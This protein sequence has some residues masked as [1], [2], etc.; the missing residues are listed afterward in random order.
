MVTISEWVDR[1]ARGARPATPKP[2]IGQRGLFD[3]SK[4]PRDHKGVQTGGRFTRSPHG[5]AASAPT[6]KQHGGHLFEQ[7]TQA[8]KP[9]Q[10]QPSQS[11][12]PVGGRVGEE[13]AV[14]PSLYRDLEIEEYQ[15]GPHTLWRAG[16]LQPVA[17]R[18][19]T[20][21]VSKQL[22]AS[23][24]PK[25]Y[26]R[27]THNRQRLVVACGMGVDSFAMLVAMK[28][29]GIR[30]DAIHW[31]DTGSER[32]HTYQAFNTLQ[33]WCQKNGFP[34]MVIVRRFAPKAGHRSLFEQS[35]NNEQ[36]PS[37]AFH[38]NHSC[39]QSWKLQPQRNWDSQCQWLWNE[40]NPTTAIGF[41][42]DEVS[43]RRGVKEAVG[44]DAEEV[45]G[46]RSG[47]TR[48]ETK[49]TKEEDAKYD[50]WFPLV[51]YGLNRQQ[52]VDLIRAEGLP[53]PGKSAC[54]MC[55]YA[56]Q[57]EIDD[58]KR[59]G[60]LSAATGLEQRFEAAQQN[61]QKYSDHLV[62]L[63]V[64]E[65]AREVNSGNTESGVSQTNQ[66]NMARGEQN[67]RAKG[68]KVKEFNVRGLGEGGKSQWAEMTGK[69]GEGP[70]KPGLMPDPLPM[71]RIVKK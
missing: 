59:T 53:V 28:K 45:G 21:R 7:P 17:M 55:P 9:V 30:P 10:P 14:D 26:P 39:S 56:K 48:Y 22:E 67:R 40:E 46:R 13:P 34:P 20:G 35:W 64:P 15:V 52:C 36:L 29:R 44:F 18:G 60:E 3:E 1:Y 41:D 37:A 63:S 43:G 19:P 65:L 6:V 16:N 24:Q 23:I 68:K 51:D 62:S 8:P 49:G 38:V 11:G 58:M 57:C 61:R 4:H 5:G 54:F 70:D 31:A 42:A 50:T 71:P 47:G 66:K 2:M 32:K 69:P 27:P 25:D 12:E 33:K